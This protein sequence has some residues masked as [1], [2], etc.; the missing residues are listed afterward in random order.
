VSGSR[1]RRWA[2]LLLVVLAIAGVAAWLAVRAGALHPRAAAEQPWFDGDF[3]DGN[4]LAHWRPDWPK[5]RTD[6][7]RIVTSPVH[8][9]GHAAEVSL[10]AGD[11]RRAQGARRA[12]P[13]RRDHRAPPRR[14]GQEAWYAWSMLVPRDFEDLPPGSFHMVVQWHHRQP[15]GGVEVTGAP[16]LILHLETRGGERVLTLW[17]RGAPT[18]GRRRSPLHAVP[19]D[20]WVELLF[21]LR[22]SLGD[23][24]FVEAW[25]D[26][27]PWTAGKVYGN[28]LYRANGNYL[29]LGLYR[30]RGYHTTNR[31]FLDD[32][33]I[34]PTRA[35]VEG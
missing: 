30:G 6:A 26:G 25:F 21:H 31:L 27:K 5:N 2:G 8:G 32:V 16:P 9:G 24:G 11:P 19:T 35:S 17:K 34:G 28:T 12:H 22:W 14:P 18:S 7:I 20:R 1:T 33:R 4:L 10:L 29:R 15:Q 13:R 23:D 3:E